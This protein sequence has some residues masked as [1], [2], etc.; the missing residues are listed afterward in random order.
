[1]TMQIPKTC[2]ICGTNVNRQ[3]LYCKRCKKLIDRIGTRKRA[4]RGACVR[5]LQQAWDGEGFRCY[6]SGIRLVE[7]NHKDPRYLT[8]DHRVPRDESDIVVAAQLIND[9]KTDVS[10]SEFKAIA[11]QLASRFQGGMFDDKVFK[12]SHFKR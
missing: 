12:L 8:F 2:E 5:A 11:I 3:A 9:M 4:D 6:Y 7:D 10:E 1:M